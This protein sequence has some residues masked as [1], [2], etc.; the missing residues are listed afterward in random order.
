MQLEKAIPKGRQAD[1]QR[2]AQLWEEMANYH[3]RYHY[4]RG[5]D[6]GVM[7]NSGILGKSKIGGFHIRK[8]HQDG[9]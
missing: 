7:F 1:L 8:E 3:R 2:F 9:G 5:F 6:D 4:S